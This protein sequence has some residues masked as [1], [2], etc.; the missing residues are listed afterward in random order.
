[1]TSPMVGAEN[2][3]S[4]SGTATP[5]MKRHGSK[6]SSVSSS[7]GGSFLHMASHGSRGREFG[8]VQREPLCLRKGE[9]ASHS[10]DME[11]ALL[12]AH[13]PGVHVNLQYDPFPAQGSRLEG[14]IPQAQW[15]PLQAEVEY[16]LTWI[17]FPYY[18][19][20]TSVDLDRTDV[21]CL[22]LSLNL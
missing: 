5:T 1:M 3:M 12:Q 7:P 4:Y 2:S 18:H 19:R 10:F 16:L 17:G 22:S 11:N 13:V 9:A 8:E 14:Q 20:T 15:R 21:P 6:G